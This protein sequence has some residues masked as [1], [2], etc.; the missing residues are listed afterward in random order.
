MQHFMEPYHRGRLDD[1]SGTGVVGVPG[2]GP[3]FVLQLR[4]SNGIVETAHFQS[5]SCGVTVASGSVLAEF[6]EGKPV[7]ECRALQTEAVV[8]LLEEIPDDKRHVPEMAIRALGLALQD[9]EGSTE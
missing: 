4:I 8:D 6:I 7:S 9:A 5:H 2:Q 3:F 1:A